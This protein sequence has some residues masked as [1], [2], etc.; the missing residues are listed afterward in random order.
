MDLK[1]KGKTALV[2]GGSRGIG[3]GTARLLAEEGCN[4]H[5]ASR[6]AADLE[7]AKKRLTDSYKVQ[8]TCHPMDLSKPESMVALAKAAGDVDILVNNAGAIPQAAITEMDDKAW[9]AAWELKIFGY[10]NLTREVYRRMCERRQGVIVNVIGTAGERPT[11]HYM[12]GSMGNS[13]LMTMT[14]ALGSESPEFGVRVV[15]VNPGA[16]ETDRQVTRWRARAEKAFGDPERWRELTTGFPF[17]RLGSVDEVCSMIVFLCSERSGYT[18][19]TIVTI[20]GGTSWQ[21]QAAK[22]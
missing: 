15:G 7:A 6:N 5:L 4:L 22:S 3:F 9:R 14:R 18:T 19:G 16:T 10:I 17:G 13:A 8:V 21:V 20:D 11:A 12:A 2:T 1:L